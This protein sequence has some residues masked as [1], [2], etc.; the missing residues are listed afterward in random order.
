M[1]NRCGGGGETTV[2]PKQSVNRSFDSPEF[3]MMRVGEDM[4]G[5]RT[6]FF[7]KKTE[8]FKIYLIISLLMMKLTEDCRVPTFPFP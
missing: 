1:E 7:G 2:T 4:S 3:R 5:G 6:E 8:K